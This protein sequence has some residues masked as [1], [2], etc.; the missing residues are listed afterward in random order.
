MHAIYLLLML[1][2]HSIHYYIKS[3]LIVSLFYNYTL[4]ISYSIILLLSII[5]VS[6][7]FIMM[8]ETMIQAISLLFF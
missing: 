2:I 3:L 8:I 6:L 4:V 5:L 1:Y 7:Q